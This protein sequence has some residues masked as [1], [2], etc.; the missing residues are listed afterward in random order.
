MEEELKKAAIKLILLGVFIPLLAACGLSQAALPT[1]TPPPPTSAPTATATATSLPPTATPAPQPIGVGN[2]ESLTEAE[3]LTGSGS[4]IRALEFSPD[5]RRLL[6]TAED[7]IASVEV[8]DKAYRSLDDNRW[9][10][11]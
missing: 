9:I 1:D 2:I 10:A 7:A 3:L 5:G 11:I 6:I 8:I 4:L